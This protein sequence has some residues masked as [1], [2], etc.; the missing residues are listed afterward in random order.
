VVRFEVYPL[1]YSF[2]DVTLRHSG[3][4]F[5]LEPVPLVVG[6]FSLVFRLGLRLRGGPVLQVAYDVLVGSRRS[7][8]VLCL[9]SDF[10]FA[11]PVGGDSL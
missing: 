11:V 5:F 8:Q 6:L 3:C 10:Y 7:G 2:G 1:S 4:A 9:F